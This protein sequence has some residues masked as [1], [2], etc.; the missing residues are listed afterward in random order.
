MQWFSWLLVVTS[1]YLWLLVTLRIFFTFIDGY[2]WLFVV[3]NV[4]QQ[5]NGFLGYWWLPVAICGY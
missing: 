2:R 5:C 1:G 4:S 3:I